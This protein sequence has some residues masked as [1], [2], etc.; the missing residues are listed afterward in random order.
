[1]RPARR[2]ERRLM[3]AFAGFVLLVAA[4]F[5]LFAF[6][7]MYSVE[8]A[9][10]ETHLADEAVLQLREHAR[11]GSWAEPRDASMSIHTDAASLPADLR[12]QHAAEPWR[13]EFPGNDGRHYHVR[14]LDPPAP[15][16][17]AWL[18]AEVS[19]QLVVRPMRDRVFLFLGGAG[20]LLVVAALL[21]GYWLARRTAAP[22]SRLAELIDGMAPERLPRH[23]AHR[24]ADDEVGILARGLDALVERI[25]SFIAREQEFTRDA[26]HELRT[27]LAVIRGAAERLAADPALSPEARE[28]VGHARQSALQLEQTVTTL[29]AL[30]REETSDAAREH[31]R[32]V[33]VL[34]RVI[35]EQSPLLDGKAVEVT[36]DVARDTEVS[37]PTSVL[38]ILLS[39]LVGNAFA[40]TD[41]GEVGIDVHDR[42][43]RIRNRDTARTSRLPGPS[44]PP[45]S[46]REGSSG[47]GLGLAIVRRLCD[48]HAIDLDIDEVDGGVIASIGLDTR[49]AHTRSEM[50]TARP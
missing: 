13:R 22:L 17:R 23:F 40:H 4:L 1:M 47:H 19:S 24:F 10:F 48:R 35:V 44:D 34:E 32:I 33:P 8:D 43:L 18:I 45:F 36:I 26:S 29:L 28:Q 14:A 15:A 3:L 25:Q 6:A 39:N 2:L 12:T 9:F 5:G 50:S 16:A 21:L 41:T 27:P 42:R 38:H 46:K 30:A 37:L 31:V 11:S 49:G 20:F 7:F